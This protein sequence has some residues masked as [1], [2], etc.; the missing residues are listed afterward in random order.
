MEVDLHPIARDLLQCTVKH[1]RPTVWGASFPAPTYPDA[2]A[3]CRSSRSHYG[4]PPW[5]F[6]EGEDK[7]VSYRKK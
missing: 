7:H 5:S 6:L 2:H 1:M 4:L 3:C